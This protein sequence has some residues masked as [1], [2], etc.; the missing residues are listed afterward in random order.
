MYIHVNDENGNIC[1]IFLLAIS[2]R[3]FNFKETSSVVIQ[4][5]LSP[6]LT[7]LCAKT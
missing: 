7:L 1:Q 3:G 5:Y 2:I 6:F 4:K